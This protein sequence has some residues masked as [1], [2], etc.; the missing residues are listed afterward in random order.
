MPIEEHGSFV[1][2]NRRFRKLEQKSKTEE[3]ALESY[4]SFLGQMGGL[5]W[6]DLLKEN[7]AVVLGEPGSGK[8]W[9]MRERVRL[10]NNQ[11]TFAF[12]V[13]LDQL[14]ER[15]LTKLFDA[16][17][18]RRFNQWKQSKNIA[19]FLLDSV[20]EAKFRKISDFHATLKRFRNELGPNLVL[21]TKIFLSSRISEWKPSTDGFEFQRL[22][23]LPPIEK[24]KGE[25]QSKE[26]EKIDQQERPDL[27]LENPRTGPV[28][29]EIKWADNWTLPQLLERL[30]NQLV[31]QYLRAHNSRYGIYFLGFIGKKQNWEEPTT[32]KQLTFDEV[33]NIVSGR[34]ISLMQTNSKIAGLEVISIDFCQPENI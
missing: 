30:E 7:R 15:E 23:P 21:Q 5:S 26:I 17:E 1:E 8:S 16:D 29:I 20:D 28:S 13:R 24:R 12:F 18:Q 25:G 31:G 14:V 33:V 32:G 22:F 27:R 9:E 6:D 4:T 2:L 10:L 19:Y 11:G 34:A 3:L